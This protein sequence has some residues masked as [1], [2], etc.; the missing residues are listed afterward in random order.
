MSE[1]EIEAPGATGAEQF[2]LK[3]ERPYIWG[4]AIASLGLGTTLRLKPKGYYRISADGARTLISI[5]RPGEP[6]T[7]VT[8]VS[9]GHANRVRQELSDM[10][11]AGF[12][13]DAR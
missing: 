3:S 9:P 6:D 5:H 13:E 7:F 12:I 2:D 8:C 10:G 4:E 1:Q 11:L